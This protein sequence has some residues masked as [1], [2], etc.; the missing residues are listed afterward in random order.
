MDDTWGE[1]FME[2]IY[3]LRFNCWISVLSLGLFNLAI[4]FWRIMVKVKLIFDANS[5]T[6]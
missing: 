2:V 4:L 1:S 6:L 3:N 5:K